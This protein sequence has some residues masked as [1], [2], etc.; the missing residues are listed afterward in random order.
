MNIDVTKCYKSLS[1]YYYVKK[2]KPLNCRL[3]T[4]KN[5]IKY[6]EKR[7][8]ISVYILSKCLKLL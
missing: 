5:S 2:I 8:T 4:G 1:K 3:K 7:I 6:S